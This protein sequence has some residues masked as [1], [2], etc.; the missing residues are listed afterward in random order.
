M[1]VFGE[2]PVKSSRKAVAIDDVQIVFVR[3]KGTIDAVFILRRIQEEYVA[4][5]SCAGALN[6]W[7]KHLTKF[8]RKSWNGQ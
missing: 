6:I 1:N 5:K 7:Q 4:K 8:K 2:L 3:G